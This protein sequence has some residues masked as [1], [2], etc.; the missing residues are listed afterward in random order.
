MGFK[1]R[2]DRLK[3]TRVGKPSK[4]DS[5]KKEEMENKYDKGRKFHHKHNDDKPKSQ[6][7]RDKAISKVMERGKALQEKSKQHAI[8]ELK[9]SKSKKS[10]SKSKKSKTKKSEPKREASFSKAIDSGFSFGFDN[11]QS[12]EQF[13]FGMFT[14]EKQEEK[15]QQQDVD[16]SKI[17][18]FRYS[19]SKRRKYNPFGSYDF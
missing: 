10:K 13:G 7:L 6:S 5:A 16:W 3:S 15:P 14:P 1:D 8:D 2:L 19:D 4:H 9:K 17:Y 12:N 11:N 18:D